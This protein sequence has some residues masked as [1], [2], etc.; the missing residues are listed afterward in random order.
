MQSTHV[1]TGAGVRR[2]VIA[3]M[4]ALAVAAPAMGQS[5]AKKGTVERLKVRGAALVGN[6]QG[7]SPERDVF[8]YFPPSYAASK[9][10]RYPVVYLL[11]G[12]SLT[13]ERWMDFTRLGEVAD[14]AIAAGT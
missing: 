2:L 3:G 1:H 14:R 10:Q 13:A 9:T 4:L 7:E 6:L 5:Q 8:I 12:Y 11:H